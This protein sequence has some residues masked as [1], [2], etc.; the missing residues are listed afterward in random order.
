MRGSGG[1]EIQTV[2]ELLEKLK[3]DM[4]REDRDK[5]ENLPGTKTELAQLHDTLRAQSEWTKT[6]GTELI[7]EIEKTMDAGKKIHQKLQRALE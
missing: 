5:M 2:P 3:N 4:M 1:K 6:K 7:R